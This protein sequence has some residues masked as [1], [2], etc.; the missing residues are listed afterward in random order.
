MRDEGYAGRFRSKSDDRV[1]I[2]SRGGIFDAHYVAP[3]PEAVSGLINDWV[4]FSS[5]SDIGI[6][7]RLALSHAQFESIHPFLDGNGRVG[8]VAIQRM[9]LLSG[10]KPLPVSSALLALKSQYF[11]SFDSYRAGDI[12]P[13]VQI[14]A[15]AVEA[16]L[17]GMAEFYAER[18]ALMSEWFGRLGASHGKRRNLY[19]AVVH[20]SEFPVF[21]RYEMQ[22]RLDVSEIT[23]RRI[24]D[25]LEADDIVQ[26]GRKRWN[27]SKKRS[28]QTWEPPDIY[29]LAEKLERN[30]E[31]YAKTMFGSAVQPEQT[32]GSAFYIDSSG[33]ITEVRPGANH[34][35]RIPQQADTS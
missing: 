23:A 1:W 7:E 10:A 3:L 5:R 14:Q 33:D 11:A 27:P 15:V 16:A 8:R 20:L 30:I 31:D 24:I 29:R 18:D 6:V 17:A 19:E 13:A 26:I 4:E 25:R 28:E 12:N 9:L 32:G 35:S 2:G 22:N 34:S 21:T